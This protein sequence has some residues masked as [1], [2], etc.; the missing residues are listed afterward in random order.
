MKCKDLVKNETRKRLNCLRSNNGGE[1]C[2]KDFDD[3]YSYHGVHR[4]KTVPRIPQQNGVS[5]RMNRTIM[6]RARSMILHVGFPLQFW[7]DDVDIVVYLIN[8]RPSSSLDGGI[9]EEAWTCK[10][11]N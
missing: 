3:C 2:K 10:K 4:E 1:H 9:L 8:I 11:V 6:E 7:V 5:E